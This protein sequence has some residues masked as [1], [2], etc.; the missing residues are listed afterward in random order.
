MPSWS[1]AAVHEADIP[2]GTIR[3][4]E[5]G[6]GDPI[7][8]VHGLLNDGQLWR[9]VAPALAQDFRVIVPDWPLGSHE[10]PMREGTDLSL[11]GLAAIVAGF[12]DALELENVTLVGNDTG[13]AVCQRV[14]VDH[15]QRI[16]RLVLTPCDAYENFLPALFTPLKYLGG[17]VPGAI[18][19]VGFSLKPAF[20]RRLPLAFG[21]LAKHG[22]PDEVTASYL[23]PGLRDRRI[24]KEIATI[25]R[26][27]DNRYTQE[28][29][30]RF[31]EFDKPVL[32]VWAT[33]DK[34]FPIK[35]GERLAQDFPDARLE[36]IDDSYTYVSE[37]QP[38]RTAELIAAF[39][40]EPVAAA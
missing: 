13:G 32:L 36:R 37:D 8:F 27:V 5:L 40:R 2:Q 33:E 34:V 10:V 38:E 19:L 11:P 9:K 17:Y 1:D 30:E 3:Y 31:R 15:P 21:W 7:V 24:R 20:A 35:F 29:A 6:T 23:A 22:I 25:L 18:R 39:A 14:I 12:L 28:A 16:A 4:R 26:G